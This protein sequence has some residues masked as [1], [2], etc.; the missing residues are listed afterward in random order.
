[1]VGRSWGGTLVQELYRNHPECVATLI[2]VGT[3]AGWRQSR[4][5]NRGTHQFYATKADCVA[6]VGSPYT[7]RD[8]LG[9][10]LLF[11]GVAAVALAIGMIPWF[12]ERRGKPQPAVTGHL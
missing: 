3:Y 12:S 7:L 9:D 6:S 2:L 8:R 10:W 11:L 1:V 4:W 5:Q